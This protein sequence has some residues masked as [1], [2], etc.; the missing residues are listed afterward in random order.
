MTAAY[1]MDETRSSFIE[2][3]RTVYELSLETCCHPRQ[4]F[5]LLATKWFIN[6]FFIKQTKRAGA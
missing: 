2:K 5:T 3:S 4:T 6:R 1:P